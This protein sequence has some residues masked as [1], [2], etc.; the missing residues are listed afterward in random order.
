MTGLLGGSE[1]SSPSNAPAPH[2][3]A[4]FPRT[5]Y[6]DNV[7]LQHALCTQHLG[8]RSLF[9]YVGFSMGGQQAY[10]MA[11]LFPGFARRVV[12]LAGSAR[13]SWH[14]YCFLEGPKAAL[15][16]SVDFHAGRYT[17]PAV[18]GTGAFGR[19]YSAWALSQAWF[20]ERCWEKCGYDTLD[21]YLETAWE[22]GLGAWDANDLL[23]LLSTW[24]KGDITVY[25][26]EDKG[27]LEK[28]LARIEAKCLIMPSRTGVSCCALPSVPCS[29]GK[30]RIPAD[31]SGRHLF[32]AR[33]QRG[34]VQAPETRKVRAHR[35]HLGTHGGRRRRHPRRLQIH[36]GAGTDIL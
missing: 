11:A 32:P 4:D 25:N 29:T 2:A 1:S 17:S 18:R 14:N 26:P 30:E 28:A 22:K 23:C 19:V 33:G 12:V 16:N 15:V 20:R 21:A 3:G 10:H 6:E 31:E 8:V 5:T 7:R 13:T 36:P 35:E 9:A 24:Q 34:G 27:S